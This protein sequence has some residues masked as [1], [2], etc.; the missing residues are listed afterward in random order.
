MAFVTRQ[1]PIFIQLRRQIFKKVF[2]LMILV[3]ISVSQLTEKTIAQVQIDRFYD[4]DEIPQQ[5]I[6]ER[7][8]ELINAGFMSANVEELTSFSSGSNSLLQFTFYSNKSFTSVTSSTRGI[9]F[10]PNGTRLYVVGRSSNNVIEYHLSTPWDIRTASYQREL[11]TASVMESQTQPQGN[12]HG[13]YI[14]QQDGLKMWLVNRT[15]I[16]EFT[17]SSAWNI[18]TATPTGYRDLTNIM[19]RAHDV[20]FKPD[21]SVMY[22]EDRFLGAVF[23]F[24]L[25][26]PWDIET[27]TLDHTFN[28]QV[29]QD[30]QGIQFYS[31]GTRMFLIDNSVFNGLKSIHEFTLTL[32]YDLRSATYIGSFSIEDTPKATS[33][34]FSP[35]F[36]Q[37]FVSDPESNRIFMYDILS[38]PDAQLS[39]ITAL[40]ERVQAN[41][42]STS[43][44]R[45]IARDSNGQP[46]EKLPVQL[47]AKSGKLDYS[48]SSATT[49]ANGEAYF[50][51]RNNRI[52]TVVYSATSLGVELAATTSVRFLGIDPERS[53]IIVS[54]NRI[55]ANLNQSSLIEV[56]TTDEDGNPFASINVEL[57]T[58][59]GNPFLENL[60][61]IT[62]SDGRAMFRISSQKPGSTQLKARALGETLTSSQIIQFLGIDPELSFIEISSNRV[63]ANGNQLV[64]ATV[65]A[66]DTDNNPFGN[67]DAELLTDGG[68]PTIDTS[69]RITNSNGQA[70]FKIVS[71]YPGTT[72]L[73]AKVFGTI[74]SDPKV[75]Q[76]LGIDPETSSYQQAADR[77]QA[78]GSDQAEI[79]VFARDEDNNPFGNASMELIPDGGS[80]IIDAVQPV[81]D[82]EGVAVFRVSNN[83]IERI[84]YQA[85]GLG[86]TLNGSVSIQFIPVAPVALSATD[87]KTRSFTANW[88]M[89]EGAATYFFDLSSDS[90]FS[91]FWPG[92]ENQ[93][94]GL[95]TSID[96]ESVLPGKSYYYRVRA[97]KNDLIGGNSESIRVHTF[98]EIPVATSATDR[99]ANRFTARW[100]QTEGAENYRLDISLNPEFSEMVPGYS[101]LNVGN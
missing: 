51:V 100:S 48:P 4:L 64:A 92:Y 15:E 2:F 75:V 9:E 36:R 101:D 39:T 77:I 83:T 10:N 6:D 29:Q 3:F 70:Q 25:T 50:D 16:W 82:S 62:N 53:L 52:E 11:D 69:Q 94:V 27:S 33:L 34:K 99:N 8:S 59:G 78:N 87:V 40:S 88:E 13:I 90:T 19:L 93:D 22:M 14:R 5:V 71:R 42:E 80:S 61:S 67:V 7:R 79:L 44:I 60:Q 54:N 41:N 46:L 45:V 31:D 66:R 24:N 68:S 85:R 76:F 55:Q 37:L 1:F 65:N 63:Q 81:T 96:I 72:Q 91:T 97:T 28:V 95:T 26:S 84:S 43:R 58:D 35:D 38:P 23:Q 30:L 74:L 32:P 56:T 73:G 49:N 21:G 98:P 57:I 12:T 18:S 86:T 20:D 47:I 89:V 17:L